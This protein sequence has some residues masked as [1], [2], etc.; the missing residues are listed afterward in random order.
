VLQDTHW[1]I[2]LIGYFSTYALGNLIS[3]QLWERV[4]AELPDLDGQFE[5][6]EFGALREWLGGNL[7]RYGRTLTPAET[8]ERV[9]GAPIDPEP[10]VRYLRGK[11]GELQA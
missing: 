9:V 1:S 4:L 2:G 5:R 6:G 7:H 10:Y 3:A 8:V 11:L